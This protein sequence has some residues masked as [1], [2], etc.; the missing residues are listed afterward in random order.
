MKSILEWS[1]EVTPGEGHGVQA[2]ERGY[3]QRWGSR[4]P[5]WY[6]IRESLSNDQGLWAWSKKTLWVW[7]GA[8]KT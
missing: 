7:G 1:Q 6:P 4:T 5:T 3:L 2:K 8:V